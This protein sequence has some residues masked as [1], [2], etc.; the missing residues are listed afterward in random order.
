MKQFSP[1]SSR[2][3][4]IKKRVIRVIKCGFFHTGRKVENDIFQENLDLGGGGGG[5][6]WKVYCMI[7]DH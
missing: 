4:S 1:P 2:F 5:N 6:V 7:W 3:S